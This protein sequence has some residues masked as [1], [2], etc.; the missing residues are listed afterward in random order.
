MEIDRLL[1]MLFVN[2][3]TSPEDLKFESI[4]GIYS[5]LLLC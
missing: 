1:C 2:S 3:P 5:K 4:L